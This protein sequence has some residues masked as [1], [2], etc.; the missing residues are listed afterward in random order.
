MSRPGVLLL[1]LLCASSVLAVPPKR[2]V[3]GVKH[4]VI[5]MR[6]LAARPAHPQ[7]TRTLRHEHEAPHL[8]HEVPPH[9]PHQQTRSIAATSLE[10][11]V[12]AVSPS[13][14]RSFQAIADDGTIIP[15]DTMGAAG[16]KHL[17]VTLNSQIRIM[18]KNGGAIS[19]T[20]L[21]TFW[22]SI[23]AFD[24]KLVY[25]ASA[26]RWIFIA[27][28]GWYGPDS[29][30]LMAVS[31]NSDP[32]GTWDK[33][34]IPADQDETGVGADFPS[35]GFN[36]SHVV[37][38]M[39]MYDGD[40][41]DS[42]TVMVFDKA[43]LYGG[44]VDSVYYVL[45]ND[46]NP[47]PAVSLTPSPKVYLVESWNSDAGY[48]KLYTVD[49]T[50]LTS[51]G[52]VSG[53][54]WQLEG[55]PL[56]PQLGSNV[57]IDLGDDRIINA[58]YRDGS[59]YAAQTAFLPAG[60]PAYGAA[61]WWKIS[62][63]LQN[64]TQYRFIGS[65][66]VSFAYP[67]VAVNAKGEMLTGFSSFNAS[68]YASAAY[69]FTAPGGTPSSPY[70][71]KAGQAPYDKDF[72]AD[73]NRWG[74]YSATVVDP[75]SDIDFWTIQ[76]YAA[77]PSPEPYVEDQWA[78]WWAN[79]VPP[80]AATAPANLTATATSASSVLVKWSGTGNTDHYELARSA[81]HI[82]YSTI[83]N[84][85]ATHYTDATALPNTS[86]LYKAR[87]IA[88]STAASA[89]S[90]A[91]PATTVIFTDAQLVV[92]VS[93]I[94]RTHVTELRNAVGAYRVLAGLSAA[95]FT[96]NT[97]SLIKAVHLT[98][99][100]TAL[101]QARVAIGLPALTFTNATLTPVVTPARAVDVMELRLGVQ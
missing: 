51:I 64:V 62:N 3:S 69:S 67:S 16:P 61:Q 18:N 44:A 39:N 14:V 82:N 37:V 72:G 22:S 75:V 4:E 43:A 90:N 25:D 73:D 77:T 33:Y 101:N 80:S 2:A 93:I 41:F 19:T 95:P 52:Y 86:Y 55:G 98:E 34:V 11:T 30:L 15:P 35:I 5:D 97:P 46:F 50:Q 21:L 92:P 31:R 6:A 10:P 13:P 85:Y 74:D 20:D 12:N 42:A 29:H 40:Y 49:D 54:P 38:N 1:T 70:I 84:A 89:Y 9:P 71:F 91:D 27:L 60:A 58:V 26:G 59:I 100:R 24:P 17:M 94:R 63:D 28:E 23:D 8:N 79:V 45:P 36:D 96:D 48:L 81:D 78:T 87:A 99:L 68:S 7:K 57:K 65:N 32:T 83:A 66:T 56:G 47:T 53:L 88:P 76:E